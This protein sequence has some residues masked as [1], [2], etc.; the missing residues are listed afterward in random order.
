MA[1]HDHSI[2]ADA[3]EA[4]ND[5]LLAELDR[6]IAAIKGREAEAHRALSVCAAE[7][8][9]IEDRRKTILQV[10]ALQLAYLNRAVGSAL[11]PPPPPPPPVAP[12][13][14]SG[15]PAK[16]LPPPPVPPPPSDHRTKTRARIGPQRYFIL[17]DIHRNGPTTI[18][19][20]NERT[21][22]S[23]KRIKDQVRS[24]INDG[25]LD[26]VMTDTDQPGGVPMLRLS[27]AGGDLLHRFI[28][29]RKANNLALPTREEAL[30]QQEEGIFS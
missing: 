28:E 12:P 1:D 5:G 23:L 27:K 3:I 25:V 8:L 26:E 17:T 16:S 13:V 4:L 21:G 30:G 29:Y 9:A 7:R 20:I 22:L 11:P 24:D 10:K 18:E 6:A 15:G 14:D 2:D 19:K